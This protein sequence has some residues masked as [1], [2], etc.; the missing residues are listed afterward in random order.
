[1]GGKRNTLQFGVD[2]EN[3]P[4]LI[5][6]SW[7]VYKQVNSMMPLTYNAKAGTY[8]FAKQGN[9]V[10]SKTYSDYNGFMSTYRIQF[11]VRYIFN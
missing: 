6:K 1:V 8:N 3:L 5:N 9:D 7:G 2:I 10:L 11:S 4:N